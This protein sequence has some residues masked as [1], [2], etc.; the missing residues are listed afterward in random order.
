M[1][2][3]RDLIEEKTIELMD[4]V[5]SSED[6]REYLE[7]LEVIRE[8]EQM[9]RELN[10]FRRDNMMVDFVENPEERSA[11]MDRIYRDHRELLTDPV[12]LRFLSC[13]QKVCRMM[14]KIYDTISE[15]IDLDMS[16][17]DQDPEDRS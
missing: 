9:Y 5:R 7:S 2:K 14:Q 8:N 6:Y 1:D 10:I 11:E 13:E 4:L 12:I 15:N 16:H 3:S 17:M